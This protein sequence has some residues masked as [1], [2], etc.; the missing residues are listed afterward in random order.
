MKGNSFGYMLVFDE[1]SLLFLDAILAILPAARVQVFED[2]KAAWSSGMILAQGARGPG[3]NSR[4]SP[5]ACSV[6]VSLLSPHTAKDGEQHR[7][8]GQALL[9]R[10]EGATGNTWSTSTVRPGVLLG[11]PSCTWRWAGS[12][13][14]SGEE[15]TAE[16]GSYLT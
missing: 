7:R 9:C 4:S 15:T 11:V 14:L 3:F 6:W 5:S 10:E 12:Q 1:A 8:H 16:R 2:S 13:V